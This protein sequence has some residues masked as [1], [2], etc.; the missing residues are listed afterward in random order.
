MTV[1]E[2]SQGSKG[3]PRYSPSRSP[4]ASSTAPNVHGNP[5]LLSYE[6]SRTLRDY[7]ANTATVDMAYTVLIEHALAERDRS[8]AVVPRCITLLKRFLLRYVP[9]VQTLRQIDSFCENSIVECE[10]I[11]KQRVSLWSKSL[12]QHSGAATNVLPSLSPAS[13]FASASLVKSLNYVRSLVAQHLPKQSF[14]PLGISGTN[15]EVDATTDSPKTKD[16]SLQSSLKVP[17]LDTSDSGTNEKYIYSDLLNWRLSGDRDYQLP[18]MIRE[19]VL[20]ARDLAHAFVEAGAAALLFDTKINEKSWKFPISQDLP[21]VDPLFSAFFCYNGHHLKAIAASKRMKGGPQQ[22]WENVSV[23]TFRARAHPLFQYRHYS[24]QQPLW[25]NPAEICEVIAEACSETSSAFVNY[26]MSSPMAK[27]NARPVTEV[28]ISVLIKLVVDM[29]VMDSAAAAPLTLSMLED[30]LSS[31]SVPARIRVFD[32]IL[33]LGVHAHLLEPV[34]YDDSPPIVEEEALQEPALNNEDQDEAGNVNDDVNVQE[35]TA[36]AIE[37]FEHWLLVILFEVLHFLVQ[38]EERE[39]IVWASALSCLFYFVCHTGNILRKRLEGLDI[40]VV[41]ALLEVSREYS[42]AEVVHCKLICMLTNLFY[43]THSGS[44]ESLGDTSTFLVEQVNLLGGINFICLEYSQAKSR[45]EKRNL[46]LVLFDYALDQINKGCLAAGAS[47]YSFDEVQLVASMLTLANAP[48]AFYT[49]LKHGLE[50]IGEVLKNSIS[51]VFPRSSN[52]GHL[53]LILHEIIK[54]LDAITNTFTH[55]DV[56]FSY[57]IQLTKSYQSSSALDGLEEGE[58]GFRT[59]LSW[60]TL[61]TLLHSERA[62]CRH[63]GYIWLVELLLFQINEV[64]GRSIWSNFEDFEQ[65]IGFACSQDP[66][67]SVVPLP[68]SIMCSLLKSKHNFIR[69][70]FLFVMERFL[71]HCKLLL[72][73]DDLQFSSHE[74]TVPPL[75]DRRLHKANA[76]IDLMSCALSLVV[77]INETDHLNILKMCDMLFSQLCLR[78]PDTN[79]M[80]SGL[81][82]SLEKPIGHTNEPRKGDSESYLFKGGSRSGKICCDNPSGS[83]FSGDESALIQETASLAALVLHGRAIVPMQLVSRVPASLFYWPLIQLAGAATDDIALGVAVGSAGRA[84]LPGATSDIRAALLLLLIG[85]CTA[86]SKAFLEVEGEEFFRGLLDDTDPRV[87]YCSAAFLLKRMMSEEPE[88]YQRLLQSLIIKAQQFNNEKLLEN[89]Y[90]QMRG[91]LQLNRLEKRFTIKRPNRNHST[92]VRAGV[93]LANVAATTRRSNWEDQL[94]SFAPSFSLTLGNVIAEIVDTASYLIFTR[95]RKPRP[96]RTLLHT[97]YL[98]QCWFLGLDMLARLPAIPPVRL[99]FWKR[100]FCSEIF[101]SRLSFYTTVEELVDKFSAFGTIR[102]A[103]IIRDPRT[104][105]PK[106]YS[107]VKYES[108]AEAQKAVNAMDGRIFGGRLIFVEIAKPRSE[109]EAE[110]A[111][112]S[113]F[114]FL[115]NFYPHKVQIESPI[116]S[117]ANTSL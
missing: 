26:T 15:F 3:A 60:G 27:Y 39:E 19:S 96:S 72:G 13:S 78:L 14:Q 40:R 56:E 43:R 22:V 49:A 31:Q 79:C 73:E 66:T 37:T 71:M 5:S 99:F 46:F 21:D 47:A 2:P 28:A 6:P 61:H 67:P 83:I 82:K 89:P 17:T 101:I 36:S 54:E 85:K 103:R 110:I 51:V 81:P 35:R 115:T 97:S 32:L 105:R 38:M 107:F 104:N 23:S 30:M 50:G 48:E 116:S 87:A 44:A 11:T 108:E 76:L 111:K 33:N 12:G 53:D 34:S 92:T 117:L 88:N 9:K 106:G 84:N 7:L 52:S 74:E 68:I 75:S 114:F 24:E 98:L 4:I 69:R 1:D 42:W 77:Q 94:P 113:S 102:D 109:D 112:L 8:P 80:P 86:D 18:Y 20:K 90:L 25:L 64:E 95:Q 65:C 41:K 63:H 59:R 16:S 10:S 62:A 55:L 91:I 29:Y 57:M 58:I 93:G 70:G 45:E 100:D